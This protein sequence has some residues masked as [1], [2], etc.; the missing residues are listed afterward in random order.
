MTSSRSPIL[1]QLDRL[2]KSSL[3]FPGQLDAI[4]R[5]Q[6]YEQSVADVQGDDL[7]WLV[8]YLNEVRCQRLPFP[9]PR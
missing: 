7:T 2:D 5:G 6:E 3:D 8:D 4:L 9:P 1:Q